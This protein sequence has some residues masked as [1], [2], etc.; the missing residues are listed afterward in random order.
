MRISKRVSSDLS[1]L[2]NI[3]NC[4]I[5]C[6]VQKLHIKP[7][8]KLPFLD[9]HV[10]VVK[11]CLLKLS[12]SDEIKQIRCFRIVSISAKSF[13]TGDRDAKFVFES[14]QRKWHKWHTRLTARVPPLCSYHILTTSVIY[15]WTD[16]GLHGNICQIK[17]LL[18]VLYGAIMASNRPTVARN[19]L[20]FLEFYPRKN[21][22]ELSCVRQFF[23]KTAH[24]SGQ[25]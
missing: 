6:Y 11:I 4:I 24:K 18:C 5:F 23:W 1:C 2:L 9:R 17:H 25:K 12:T 20:K 3:C 14:L 21:R 10:F 16:A 13:K 15:S 22:Q 7:F 8:C 19:C